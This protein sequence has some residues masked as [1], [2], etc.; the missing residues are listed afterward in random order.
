MDDSVENETSD[1]FLDFVDYLAAKKG[2]DRD[3]A[4]ELMK[5]LKPKKL[6]KKRKVLH[7]V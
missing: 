1:I 2:T 3:G 4:A 7:K 5:T 6:A